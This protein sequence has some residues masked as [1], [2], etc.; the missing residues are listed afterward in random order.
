MSYGAALP[1][2]AYSGSLGA[3]H[4]R[5]QPAS[6]Q[7]ASM[8]G[9]AMRRAVRLGGLGA[10]GDPNLCTDPGW[11]VA[12]SLTSTGMNILGSA[13]A[14]SSTKAEGSTTITKS[15]SSAGYY[16]G[17]IGSG[18]VAAW[19]AGC[20]AEIRNQNMIASQQNTQMLAD[21]MEAQRQA[22]ERQIAQNRTAMEQQLAAMMSMSQQQRQP[23][24]TG[25]IDNNT[26]L[27]GGGIVAA[28]IVAVALLR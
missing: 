6:N 17:E 22:T 12:R 9:A 23:A 1:A 21:Q 3:Y 8:R 14:P 26:L 28:A 2:G 5:R 19:D 20:E 15:G 7:G 10:L 16:A 13:L 25:G 27:I 24:Q 11:A 18:A 4:R